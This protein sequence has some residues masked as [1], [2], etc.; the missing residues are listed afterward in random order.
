[1]V[2][3]VSSPE[4]AKRE[5]AAIAAANGGRIGMSSE[6]A[7]ELLKSRGI[8]PGPEGSILA[9]PKLSPDTLAAYKAQ[10]ADP[11]FLEKFPEQ[12]AALKSSVDV[13]LAKTKQSL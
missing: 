7:A 13:A 5:L 11:V 1:M 8:E 3:H 12:H 10:L 4:L 2:E 9:V 6:A